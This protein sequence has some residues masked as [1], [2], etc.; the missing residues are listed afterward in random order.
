MSQT[1]NKLNIALPNYSN[2]YTSSS[3]NRTWYL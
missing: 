3:L 1:D 2:I